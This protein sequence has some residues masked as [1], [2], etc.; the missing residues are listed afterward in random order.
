MPFS[1]LE[2]IGILCILMKI[3]FNSTFHPIV[4]ISSSH[5]IITLWFKLGV[6]NLFFKTLVTYILYKIGAGGHV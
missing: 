5:L 1:V 2:S 4:I 3:K 6:L